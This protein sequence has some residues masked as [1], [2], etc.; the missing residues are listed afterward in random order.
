M[1]IVHPVYYESMF[2]WTGSKLMPIPA[3]VPVP[4]ST[5]VVVQPRLRHRR[6]VGGAVNGSNFGGR[7]RFCKVARLVGRMKTKLTR[8]ISRVVQADCAGMHPGTSAPRS[9][10]RIRRPLPPGTP[11]PPVSVRCRDEVMREIILFFAQIHI[12][13]LLTCNA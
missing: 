11:V 9:R 4:R 12:S 3:A 1:P 2:C 5:L 13:Q 6:A 10:P 7:G 8:S